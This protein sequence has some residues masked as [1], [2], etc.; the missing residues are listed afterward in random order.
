MMFGK[1]EL[2]KKDEMERFLE[3][4]MKDIGCGG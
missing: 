3:E 4:Q 2:P 1:L